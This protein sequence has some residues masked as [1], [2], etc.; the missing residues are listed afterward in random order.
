MRDAMAHGGPDDAG[1]YLD[2]EKGVALGHR[3]LS[4]LDLSSLGHQPMGSDDKSVWITFNGEIYNFREL[5]KELE[6]KG[7]RFN[8]TCDTEVIIKAYQEWGEDAFDKFNGMFAFCIYDRKRELLY[9]VRDPSGIKPLYYSVSDE[10]LVFSS[11]VK[12]LQLLNK[13]WDEFNDWRIYLL[14]FG[15]IPEPY[16]TLRDVYML[17][18]GS[19]LKLSLKTKKHEIKKYFEFTYSESI[20]DLEGAIGQIKDGFRKAVERHLISDAPIGVFLSGGID[21]SLITLIAHHFQKD[22]LRTLSVIFNEKEFSEKA[23]QDIVLDKIRS[24]HRSYLVTEKDFMNNLGDIFDAMD[25]PT[26]DGINTYFISKCAKEEGL[27]AVLS[28]LGGDELFGGY[29][30]FNRIDS[31]WFLRGLNGSLRKLSRMWDYSMSD[32]LKKL[33]FFSIQNPLA[34][35]L[36]FRALFSVRETAGLLNIS[37][38][39]VSGALEKLFMNEV[40]QLGRKN[41][42]SYLETNLY[43]QNQLLKDTDFMSMHHAVEVRVPFLDKRFMETVCS[44]SESIKF[45]KGSQKYLLA[46]AFE[47]VLPSEILNRK[48]Q[49]FTFPFGAWIKKCGRDLFTNAVSEGGIDKRHS[50]KLWQEFE[51]GS[52][53]WSRIWGLTILG[54]NSGSQLKNTYGVNR[55]NSRKPEGNLLIY[56]IGQLGDTLVSMPAIQAIRQKF[57]DHRLILLTDY[58]QDKSGYVSSWDVLEPTGW[59]DDVIFYVPSKTIWDAAKNGFSL[60]QKL[61]NL[62]PEYVFNLSPERNI[63]QQVR[64]GLF[65]KNLIGPAHYIRPDKDIHLSNSR[66]E[67]IVT[68]E[69]EW[70]RLLRIAGVREFDTRFR[71]PIPENERASFQKLSITRGLPTDKAF[72]LAIGPGSKMAAKRWPIARFAELGKLL[73]ASFPQL[74]LLVLGGKEDEEIGNELCRFW[75]ERSTNLAGKLSIYGSAA[76]LEK[77]AAFI[78]NDTG[79]M[80]LAALTGKP[81]VALFSARDEAGKWYPYG[82]NHIILRHTTQCAGC[83]MEECKKYNNQCLNL[84]TTAEA[85]EAAKKIIKMH[86]EN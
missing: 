8:S 50:E 76:A 40:P 33:S 27:K 2:R 67:G 23:Y 59:F 65:F 28:G 80:H 13:D 58:H 22:N 34:Y 19:F 49:G 12:P 31:V 36:A 78:G 17:P 75:A 7:H 85:F 63:W 74:H 18:K 86:G 38:K 83:M 56:R 71:L 82:N 72:F 15:H 60:L 26:T 46:R 20:A 69:P 79:T 53:H 4:I 1:L 81:C 51:N 54:H 42:V 14:I 44:I 39:E 9:L 16:T 61:R 52:V 41:F 37:E 32:K 66:D 29:P 55:L 3:R 45:R 30:S 70:Q 6:S 10:R 77:C 11:E 35:Y 21:S 43:M 25:Q 68:Y 24:R 47:D 57:P 62:S 48:K 5:K 73:V 84:I 64:D